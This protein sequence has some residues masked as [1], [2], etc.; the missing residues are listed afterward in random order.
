MA[1]IIL[2]LE[3][4]K[5]IPLINS[6][7]NVKKYPGLNRKNNDHTKIYQNHVSHILNTHYIITD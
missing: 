6:V 1:G 3:D 7:N 2:S 5:I 4:R